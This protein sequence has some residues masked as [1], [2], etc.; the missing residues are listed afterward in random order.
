MKIPE[1]LY[2]RY[3]DVLSRC[4]PIIKNLSKE[5]PAASFFSGPFLDTDNCKGLLILHGPN[6]LLGNDPHFHLYLPLQLIDAAVMKKKL[7]ISIEDTIFSAF[8]HHSWSVLSLISPANLIWLHPVERHYPFLK[9]C[10]T[11]WDTYE[12]ES[13]R[14]TDG[15]LHGMRLWLIVTNV[16]HILARQGV[17]TE[18]LNTDL[19]GEDIKRYI[20]SV[21][22]DIDNRQGSK[23][24]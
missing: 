17:P 18:I 23:R 6:P 22:T 12:S 15:S 20:Q 14:Y 5:R 8:L 13:D 3:K 2:G 19:S 21:I 11:E 10:L 1:L 24:F 16:K 9:A 4:R 7:D